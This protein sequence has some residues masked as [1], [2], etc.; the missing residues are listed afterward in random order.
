MRKLHV[1]IL[2]VDSSD[3]FSVLDIWLCSLC[4]TN[5]TSHCHELLTVRHSCLSDCFS[6]ILHWSLI[7]LST[8]CSDVNGSRT[9]QHKS[10]LLTFYTNS[11]HFE[12]HICSRLVSFSPIRDTLLKW[13]LKRKR[14]AVLF[15]EMLNVDCALFGINACYQQYVVGYDMRNGTISRKKHFFTVFQAVTIPKP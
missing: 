1:V 7:S 11:V 15:A 10:S 2:A 9:P 3:E 12:T 14:S 5:L 6:Q 4:L 13:R 8:S